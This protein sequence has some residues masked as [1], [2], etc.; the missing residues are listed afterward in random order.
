MDVSGIGLV[1]NLKAS[2]TFPAGFQVSQFADDGDSISFEEMEIGGTAMGLN[3]DL[4]TWDK[5]A[6]IS[7]PINVIPNGDDDINLAVLLE[8]N[9]AGKGKKTARDV[10]TM[11][12]VYPNG[13]SVT[14]SGGKLIKGKPSNSVASEGRMTSKPY[15]FMFENITKS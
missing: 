12:V 9:R 5:V 7:V 3:G 15:T 6:P 10:I 8:A 1:L 11:T 13:K 4:I 14:L 2:V